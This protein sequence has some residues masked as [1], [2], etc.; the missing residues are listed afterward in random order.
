MA[1]D[2]VAAVETALLAAPGT[3]DVE[4]VSLGIGMDGAAGAGVAADGVAGALGPAV[5]AGAGGGLL[6]AG[7]DGCFSHPITPSATNRATE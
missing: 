4:G 7:A 3:A 1:E 2:C 6:V 5:P